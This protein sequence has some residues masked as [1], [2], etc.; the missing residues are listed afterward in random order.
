MKNESKNISLAAALAL[1]LHLA[2]TVAVRL[3]SKIITFPDSS[4][5]LLFTIAGALLCLCALYFSYL[6]FSKQLG[7][8][9]KAIVKSTAFSHFD[10]LALTLLCA[11]AVFLFGN[12]YASMFPEAS[13]LSVKPDASVF[14]HI[15]IVISYVII[16]AFF[17]ELVFRGCFARD[18]R[19]YG[20]TAAVI[21]SA[22][23]FGL[24]HFSFTVFP[25]AFICGIIIGA[26]YLMTG[27]FTVAVGIHFTNNL[28]GYVL[29]V[30]RSAV[31]PE[32]YKLIVKASAFAFALVALACGILLVLKFG[33]K[34]VPKESESDHAPSWEFLTTTMIFYLVCAFS[35]H[36]LLG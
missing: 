15:L 36:L 33:K 13:T 30:I 25:Y 19:V 1:L 8:E 24:T 32:T 14:E 22:L 6:A 20:Q 23:L 28:A 11:A 5:R 10:R 9:R 21:L 34:P 12:V 18:F 29:T 16:P 17:E 3:I 31:N 4:S 27:S 7:C 26:A 2:A 35:A